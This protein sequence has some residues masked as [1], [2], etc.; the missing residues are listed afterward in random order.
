MCSLTAV[1]CNNGQLRIVNGPNSMTGRVEVCV[2]ETY[3][4]V[5]DDF[6]DDTDAGVVCRLAGFSRFSE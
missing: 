1:L 3:G 5:C 4:T 2:N 6:W